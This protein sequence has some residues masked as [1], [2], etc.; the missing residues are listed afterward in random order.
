M[1]KTTSLKEMLGTSWASRRTWTERI[2][3]RPPGD[4]GGT[5]TGAPS[6]G[7]HPTSGQGLGPDVGS[8]LHLTAGKAG[9]PLCCCLCSSCPWRGVDPRDESISGVGSA[10]R[11]PGPSPLHGPSA[12]PHAATVLAVFNA[13]SCMK[14]KHTCF[15]PPTGSPGLTRRTVSLLVKGLETE[16]SLTHL[17]C[18]DCS[19]HSLADTGT[20]CS[21]CFSFHCKYIR[22]KKSWGKG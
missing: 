9:K 17:R 5:R 10:S 20:G 1:N 13:L 15:C 11:A 2:Y 4:A 8:C 21:D 18:D 16:F 12:C 7:V 3:T 22:D 6:W 19:Q 14:W